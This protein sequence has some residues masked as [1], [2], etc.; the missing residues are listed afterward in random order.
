MT[1]DLV[2]TRLPNVGFKAD[3]L[4]VVLVRRQGH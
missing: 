3:G 2:W 4:A 1:V